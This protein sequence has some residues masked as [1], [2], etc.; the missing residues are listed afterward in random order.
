[1]AEYRKS[2][3]E[4]EAKLQAYE[5]QAAQLREKI[6][7]LTPPPP[8]AVVTTSKPSAA[9]RS[10]QKAG[11]CVASGRNAGTDAARCIESFN[12]P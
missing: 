8:P 1:M 9:A 4:Y 10:T 6:A 3:R 5:E 11:N 2:I 12:R 7:A